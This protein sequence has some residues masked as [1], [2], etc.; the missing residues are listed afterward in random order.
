MS[1]I[2]PTG[3]VSL[4]NPN[5]GRINKPRQIHLA[6]STR[7]G[8][9]IICSPVLLIILMGSA[10][11]KSDYK[12]KKKG[13]KKRAVSLRSGLIPCIC[14][15]EGSE[16]G[17]CLIWPVELLLPPDFSV[18]SGIHFS[19]AKFFGFVISWLP[20]LL[21]ESHPWLIYQSELHLESRNHS[22]Y[23]RA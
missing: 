5:T 2:Y 1:L 19:S 4:E 6:Q 3:S 13:P 9:G 18:P 23:F 11:F 10:W 22:R 12:D 15:S 14:G 16:S 8:P 17:L 20:S 21:T 7:R